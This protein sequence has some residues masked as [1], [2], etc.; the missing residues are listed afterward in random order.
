MLR[1]SF[2]VAALLLVQQVFQLVVL[3][4]KPLSVALFVGSTRLRCRLLGDLADVV[5]QD[6]DASCDLFGRQ[7]SEVG[8]AFVLPAAGFPTGRYHKRH[9][10]PVTLA[11]SRRQDFS[12]LVP[13]GKSNIAI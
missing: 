3:A 4:E 8:H 10:I 12:K 6:R 1:R 9:G 13:C 2:P 11:A 7:G 5:A